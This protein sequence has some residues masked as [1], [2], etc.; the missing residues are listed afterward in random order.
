MFVC[1]TAGFPLII[2]GICLYM[3]LFFSLLLVFSPLFFSHILK[4]TC[5]D[6]WLQ[7]CVFVCVFAFA[8]A[9]FIVCADLHSWIEAR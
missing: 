3:I 2:S 1:V 4:K 5:L 9:F 6:L 7:W 8:F